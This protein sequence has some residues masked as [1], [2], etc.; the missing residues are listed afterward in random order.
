M[1]INVFSRAGH[2]LIGNTR[3]ARGL[4]RHV[5]SLQES[6]AFSF[7]RDMNS[8]RLAVDLSV[9]MVVLRVLDPTNTFRFSF[10]GMDSSCRQELYYVLEE[11]KQVGE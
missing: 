11:V 7:H 10:W 9:N 3:F 8:Y 2:G 6:T 5:A 4:A 1:T